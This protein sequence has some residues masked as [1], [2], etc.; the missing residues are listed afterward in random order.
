MNARVATGNASQSGVPQRARA[1]GRPVISISASALTVTGM[2]PKRKTQGNASGGSAQ[3][4]QSESTANLAPPRLTAA[5]EDARAEQATR[6]QRKENQA[7]AT[8]RNW[9]PKKAE[10]KRPRSGIRMSSTRRL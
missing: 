9:D 3:S 6:T 1:D 7:K 4:Q 8:K 5:E 2:A 10:F